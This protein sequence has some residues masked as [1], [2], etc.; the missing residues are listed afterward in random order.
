VLGVRW[1]G[2]R[3]REE[4]ALPA[5][6]TL[7][8]QMGGRR[9]EKRKR[10]RPSAI[11]KLS[12]EVVKKLYK[13]HGYPW[14]TGTYDLN[15]GFIRTEKKPAEASATISNKFDDIEFICFVDEYGINQIKAFF[16]TTDPGRVSLLN[17]PNAQGCAVILPQYAHAV[18]TPGLHHGAAALIQCGDISILRDFDRDGE[19]DW[20]S[21]RLMLAGPEA[22]LR[23]HYARTDRVVTNVDNW[24]A[25]CCVVPDCRDMNDIMILMQK[26]IKYGHGEKVSFAL[27]NESEEEI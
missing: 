12:Y 18:W 21:G 7:P 9:E 10:M 14:F 25:G 17:P 20:D 24:S 2:E 11:T 13:K 23:N 26:Q 5:K 19:I 6:A 3:H 8:L 27:F 15:L 4:L 16:C 22:Q 1:R